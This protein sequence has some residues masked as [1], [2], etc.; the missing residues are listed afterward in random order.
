MAL[1]SRNCSPKNSLS[2]V[3]YDCIA[4]NTIYA[5]I[6]FNLT[7]FSTTYIQA[8]TSQTLLSV[9]LDST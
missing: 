9:Y 2:K 1:T 6:I 7:N 3:Q 5:N 8:L 4:S